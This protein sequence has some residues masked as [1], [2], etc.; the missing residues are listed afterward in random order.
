MMLC[1]VCG[2]EAKACFNIAFRQ[3]V[4]RAATEYFKPESTADFPTNP[5]TGNLY[6]EEITNPKEAA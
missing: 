3:F 6:W 1:K 5:A 2:K 4:D